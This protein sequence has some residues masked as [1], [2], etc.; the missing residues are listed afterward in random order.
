[1]KA[2]HAVSTVIAL[3]T[4][5][6]VVPVQA[7]G[8]RILH[9]C[10]PAPPPRVVMFDQPVSAAGNIRSPVAL[11]PI[12]SYGIKPVAPLRPLEL[13]DSKETSSA[14]EGKPRASE[15]KQI[16]AD[17]YRDKQRK[18]HPYRA[19]PTVSGEYA[20]YADSSCDKTGMGKGSGASSL[21]IVHSA[22][23]A[24]SSRERYVEVTLSN[25]TDGF[26]LFD[27]HT[28]L[29]AFGRGSSLAPRDAQTLSINGKPATRYERLLPAK[30][31]ATVRLTWDHPA[32]ELPSVV[33]LQ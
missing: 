24:P 25:P 1:M 6:A 23:P 16:C 29:G 12:P 17:A 18:Q 7:E 11:Q 20:N 4:L 3:I 5:H 31:Q 21:V 9:H 27:E 33:V 32:E 26:L 8:G 10:K 22:F 14:R 13:R 19:R 15:R 30:S 28:F 2:N